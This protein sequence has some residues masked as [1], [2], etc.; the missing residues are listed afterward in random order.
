MS[1]YP[2]EMVKYADSKKLILLS[3]Y[4]PYKIYGL[5]KHAYD[6]KILNLYFYFKYLN[7]KKINYYLKPNSFL[8]LIRSF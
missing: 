3:K 4:F 8:E 5:K 1:G 6:W 7:E 2:N